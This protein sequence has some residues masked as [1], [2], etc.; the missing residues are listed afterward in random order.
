MNILEKEKRLEELLKNNIKNEKIGTAIAITGAWGVGKTFFWK[1][2]LD[3]QLSDER[4]YKKDNVFNRKYAYVSL[5]GLESLSDLKTH[6]YS[7]IESFH[8]TVEI[9]KW[10][11]SLPS[12]FK[13]TRVTQLGISAPVKLIDNLMFSRVSDAI[14][15]FDDFER[16]SDKLNINDVMG[17]ANYLKLEK[18]CQVILILDEDKA[19]GNNKKKYADYKEKLIDETIIINSVEPLIRENA[20]NIHDQLV[21]LMIEFADKLEIHNFRFFQKVIKL[22]QYFLSEL[23]D[24]VAYSTKEIILIRILQGY[25]I[26]DFQ[27]LEYRWDDCQYYIEQKRENW[28]D[29]KKQTYE[30]LQKVSYSFNREDEWLIQF[31]KWFEQRD[32]VDFSELKKLAQS[33]LISDE[34]NQ[35]KANF[36]KL[37]D[38]F[39]GLSIDESFSE[40]LFIASEQVIGLEGLHNLSFALDILEQLGEA[41]KVTLLERKIKEWIELKLGENRNAFDKMDMFGNVKHVFK[42][43]ILIYKKQNEFKGLPKLIDVIHQYIDTQSYSSEHVQALENATKSE[44][45]QVL[46][47]QIPHDDRF[48][49]IN[50]SQVVE[51]MIKQSMKSELNSKIRKMI[52][53]VYEAKGQESAFHKRYMD[54][55]I[56]RLDD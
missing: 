54:Y 35:K 52:A 55:L 22:F 46:F 56:S 25:L 34:N 1:S 26:H 50:S 8:S 40:K 19:E 21:N 39:W 12:V 2:F 20:K 6:I 51:K 16:M 24:E 47:A 29:R 11:K 9:P 32:R 15:C 13:D 23:P 3:K 36:N 37:F 49:R 42:D 27:Q 45:E 17:L 7:S 31:Q 30:S 28:S 14:I 44:W 18:N 5:F 4:V 38:N 41:Q 10:I 43:F 33:D 48:Q 53:E